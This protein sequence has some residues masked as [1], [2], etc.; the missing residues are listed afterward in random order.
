MSFVLLKQVNTIKH[1]T[2]ITDPISMNQRIQD[3]WSPFWTRDTSKD[4]TD[5]MQWEDSFHI[6]DNAIQQRPEIN[7]PVADIEAWR[8]AIR[9]TKSKTAKGSCGFSKGELQSLPDEAL[10]DLIDI[11]SS[12]AE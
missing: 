5:E 7:I 4:L 3:F 9:K 8:C 1:E 2:W 10:Q 12:F 11:L 6:I